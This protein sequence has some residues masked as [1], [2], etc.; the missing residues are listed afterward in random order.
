MAEEEGELVNS[1]F[2]I[3]VDFSVHIL[4]VYNVLIT[5]GIFLCLLFRDLLLPL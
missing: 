5:D 1:L 4:F 3:L 2:C